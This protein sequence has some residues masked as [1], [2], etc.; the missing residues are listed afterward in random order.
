L[1]QL[2]VVLDQMGHVDIAKV[3]LGQDILSNLI[4]AKV[5]V[6][7]SSASSAHRIPVDEGIVDSERQDEVNQ[8]LLDG[9]VALL[10]IVGLTLLLAPKIKRVDCLAIHL[11]WMWV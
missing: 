3:L 9:I 8:F 1:R 7:S 2:F 6:W 4:P 5:L 10:T 11:E